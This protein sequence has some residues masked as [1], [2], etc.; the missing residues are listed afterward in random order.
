[1]INKGQFV[2]LL[3]KVAKKLQDVRV[4]P[5]GVILQV[6]R[7]DQMVA[8]HSWSD[9]SMPRH[10][11]LCLQR[12]YSLGTPWRGSSARYYWPTLRWDLSR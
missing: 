3:A 8:D 5:M 1:M 12:A 9:T 11:Q 7:R 2:V 4:S 6:G 10:S